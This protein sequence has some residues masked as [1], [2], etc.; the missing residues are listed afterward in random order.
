MMAAANPIDSLLHRLDKVKQN[1]KGKWLALCPAHDDKTP[2]L[3][4]KETDDGT[5]LLKCWAGCPAVDIVHGISL[6]LRDLFPRTINHKPRTAYH[7][8]I[9]IEYRDLLRMM[10]KDLDIVCICAGDVIRGEF[11]QTDMSA[12]ADATGRIRSALEAVNV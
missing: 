7:Q 10:S 12:L 2:S 9:H 8:R 3:S 1:G 6:E 5:I 11:N 4:I